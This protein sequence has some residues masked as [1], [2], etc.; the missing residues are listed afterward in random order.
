MDCVTQRNLVVS[1][2]MG[3]EVRGKVGGV[4]VGGS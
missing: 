4:G 1:N 2:D 3:K